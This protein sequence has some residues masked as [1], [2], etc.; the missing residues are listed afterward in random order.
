MYTFMIENGFEN[1]VHER[2]LVH[3]EKFIY[4]TKRY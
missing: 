3:F 4:Y 1:N 2:R